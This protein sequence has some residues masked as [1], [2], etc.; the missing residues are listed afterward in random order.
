MAVPTPAATPQQLGRFTLK[1]LLGQGSQATVWLAWDPLLQREVAIKLLRPEVTGDQR[2]AWLAE[3][4]LM[5]GLSH[6]NIVA[7]HEAVQEGG[8]AWMVLERVEGLTLADRLARQGAMAPREAAEMMLQVLDALACAHGH[9][10]IH[11]DLKPANVLLARD[12]R[13]RVMDFGIAIRLSAAPD[14]RIVGSVA[15]ISPEGASG[16]AATPAMDIFAAGMLLGHALLGQPLRTGMDGLTPTAML[17]RAVAEPVGWPE[18]APQLVDDPLRAL[19]LRAVAAQPA[20]R[21]ESAAAFREALGGWLNPEAPQPAAS[22]ATLE[23]LLRR[24][25][26]T[27]DFPALS[28]SVMRIQRV[29]ASDSESVH[30]LSAEILKDVALTHKLLRLVNTVHFSHLG[31][32]AITTVSRAAALVGFAGI[33][34]MAMSVMLLEHMR[35]RSHAQRMKEMFLEALMTAMVTDQLTPPSPEREEAFLAGMFSHLGRLLV[36]YYFPDEAERVRLRL[37]PPSDGSKPRP[38]WHSPAEAHA[39]REVLGL[40]FDALGLGVAQA[41]GLPDSLCHALRAAEG[42][43]P[44]RALA[45]TERLRWA[46]RAAGEMVQSLLAAD[47]GADQ[48]TMRR[49]A[50]GYVRGLAMSQDSLVQAVQKA[51]QQLA[52]LATTMGIELPAK[53]RARRLLGQASV[54]DATATLVLPDPASEAHAQDLLAAGIAEVTETLAGD[55]VVLNE[56]LRMILETLLRAMNFRRVV[57]ATRSPRQTVM[58]ARLAL[59][60]G[61]QELAR[62]V[63]VNLQPSGAMD[64]FAAA[65]LKGL[66]TQIADARAP[67]LQARLPAWCREAGAKSFLLMPLMSKGVPLGMIYADRDSPI[68]VADRELSLLRTLRNQ[69]VMAFKTAG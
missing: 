56:V 53:A 60:E 18:P 6:P 55:H 57:L 51:Q 58:T 35:N 10:I 26:L 32:G 28:D 46:V 66:D 13:A 65:C 33:R 23:F 43:M 5:S 14:G 17:Q 50:S 8:R 12:G 64:L 61:A 9:G 42:D 4:R 21:F 54:S 52:D 30:A 49:L 19:V 25:R 29:T 38:A 2:D 39:A 41:W 69:A 1:A 15:T 31:T 44:Q 48:T 7:V 40:D 63:S 37:V 20:M 45:G 34:N 27:G 24:M 59:G 62:Q 36:A 16:Q 47:A 11:R 67:D 68:A 3:A 22:H